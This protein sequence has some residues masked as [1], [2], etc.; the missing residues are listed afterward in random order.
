LQYCS[1]IFSHFYM[2]GFES[3]VTYCF[4]IKNIDLQEKG[5]HTYAHIH[6]LPTDRTAYIKTSPIIDCQESSSQL[7]IFKDTCTRKWFIYSKR[8][9]RASFSSSSVICIINALLVDKVGCSSWRFN[10]F[11]MGN[12]FPIKILCDT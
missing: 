1:I 7:E 11:Q 10:L 8:C 12:S 3:N 6:N 4:S 5:R 2:Y 9:A